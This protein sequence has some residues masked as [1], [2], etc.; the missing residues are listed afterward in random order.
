MLGQFV[1]EASPQNQIAELERRLTVVGLK[2]AEAIPLL[3]PLLNLPLPA[4]YPPSTLAPEQQ[5]RRLLATLVEW[6]LGAARTQ[7]L[8]M[9]IEDLHWVDPS[10]LELIQLLVEQGATAPLLL[11]YTARPEFRAPWP[12][13]AHHTQITLNRLGARDIRSIIAQVAASK[14]LSDDTVTAVVERTG[15]VPLF[16]EELTRSLLEGGSA[17][18]T[19]HEIPATLHDSLM[20]RLD[21]LGP[22]KEVIQIGAVIGSEFS[23]EL[24]QAAHPLIAEVRSTTSTLAW[25]GRCRNLLY[26]RGIAPDATYQFKHAL[27]Q[28]VAYEALL[29][30]RRKELHLIVAR[31]IDEKFPS[32]KETHPEV[33]ARHWTEAGEVELAIAEW[34]RAGAAAQTRNAFREALES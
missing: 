24:L 28:D 7:P 33:L 11:L 29:K 12:P 21:R 30:S 26:V 4:E 20:A 27:I 10:T 2:P 18:Q 17:G 1:G 34:T 9:A 16:V 8:V 13:R 31:T 25:P 23:Y 6:V 5:R 14:A 15:G 19:G 32:L 22:A 3:A